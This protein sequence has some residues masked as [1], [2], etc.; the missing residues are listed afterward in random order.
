MTGAPAVAGG[1]RIGGRIADGGEPCLICSP[2]GAIGHRVNKGTDL[3]IVLL[4]AAMVGTGVV[5]AGPGRSASAPDQVL[6]SAGPE[7]RF[8]CG[9]EVLRAKLR[10]GRMM[11]QTANGEQAVLVRVSGPRA[12]PKA[13][14]YGDGRLTL[15][16]VEGAGSWTLIR[17]GSAGPPVSCTPDR[18]IP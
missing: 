8:R 4:L 2:A 6:R 16:K 15:Y 11:V 9:S 3:R 7:I 1:M 12:V 14:A 17:A 5:A 10:G 18:R 13:P